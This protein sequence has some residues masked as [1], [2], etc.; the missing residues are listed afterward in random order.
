MLR[1][2]YKFQLPLTQQEAAERL[3]AALRHDKIPLQDR[4]LGFDVMR[5]SG[6]VGANEFELFPEG[7]RYSRLV[8][9]RGLLAPSAEGTTVSGYVR[10]KMFFAAYAIAI[11][12]VVGCLIHPGMAAV[13]REAMWVW[14]LMMPLFLTMYLVSYFLE[15]EFVIGKLEEVLRAPPTP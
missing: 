3:Q 8:A 1:K 9:V 2:R 5:F 4:I 13:P 10:P 15:A 14:V 12:L 6:R 7:R 11:C